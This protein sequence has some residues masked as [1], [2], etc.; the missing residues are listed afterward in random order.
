[1]KEASSNEPNAVSAG[2]ELKNIGDAAKRKMMKRTI[3]IIF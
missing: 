3:Q 2:K 1:M